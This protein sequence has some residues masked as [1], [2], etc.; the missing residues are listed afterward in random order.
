MVILLTFDMG[1]FAIIKTVFQSKENRRASSNST[2]KDSSISVGNY[3]TNTQISSRSTGSYADQ[4]L[5][6][7]QINSEAG[8]YNYQYK[9]GRRY[10]AQKDVSYLLPNDD[11]EV[12][13]V[14]QQHWILRHAF[15]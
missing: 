7:K 3:T 14:H 4:I 10:H 2:S 12:D 5:T 15:Q 9:D 13:R 6:A 11:D 1:V 8:G